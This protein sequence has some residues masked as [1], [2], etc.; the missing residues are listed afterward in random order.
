MD[1][2]VALTTVLYIWLS[3]IQAPVWDPSKGAEQFNRTRPETAIL[4]M[5][6]IQA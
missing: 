4:K 6:E 1:N 5:L 2:H 3:K